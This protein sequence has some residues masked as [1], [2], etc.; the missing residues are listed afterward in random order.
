MYVIGEVCL[1]C[2]RMV[3]ELYSTET[4]TSI[5]APVSGAKNDRRHVFGEP[6]LTISPAHVSTL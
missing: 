1:P 3:M 4:W 5:Y 6:C 2:D